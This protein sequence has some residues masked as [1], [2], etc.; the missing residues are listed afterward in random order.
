[1]LN[2]VTVCFDTITL[3]IVLVPGFFD[4]DVTLYVRP[5]LI[6]WNRSR[7]FQLSFVPNVDLILLRVCLFVLLLYVPVNSFGHE[8]TVRSPNRTFPGQACAK[9]F[10]NLNFM[11]TWCIN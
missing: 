9:D 7:M 8:G 11:M 10:W 3:V 1:M 6:P 4:A 2:I 5:R